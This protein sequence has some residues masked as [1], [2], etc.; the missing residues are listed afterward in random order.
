M[1]TIL[2]V[3]LCLMV[4]CGTVESGEIS[5]TEYRPV[6]P[7]GSIQELTLRLDGITKYVHELS[8]LRDRD[9]NQVT[10]LK[11][12]LE[13]NQARDERVINQLT[14]KIA[15]LTR[16]MEE[17][18]RNCNNKG[19]YLQDGSDPRTHVLHTDT[20]DT[21]PLGDRNKD[22]IE[23]AVMEHADNRSQ[24]SVQVQGHLSDIYPQRLTHI[25]YGIDVTEKQSEERDN[26]LKEG[27]TPAIPRFLER[28]LRIPPAIILPSALN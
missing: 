19:Q 21:V 7:I 26:S 17:L 22:S 25:N 5:P 8:G 6:V 2:I 23:T 27:Q 20:S 3:F 4:M 1:L 12:Q 9:A 11:Q 13:N 10:K 14:M 15:Q 28:Q 16:R 24:Q 18:E